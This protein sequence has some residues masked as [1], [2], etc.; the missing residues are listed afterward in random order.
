MTKALLGITLH[1]IR[2]HSIKIYEYHTMKKAIICFIL[3]W[4]PLFTADAGN[5]SSENPGIV[6]NQVRKLLGQQ[7]S[8]EEQRLFK[9]SL[10]P[11]SEQLLQSG[12]SHR[13]L[14][15]ESLR[16]IGIGE[17]FPE[18]FAT[19]IPFDQGAFRLLM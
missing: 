14:E 19:T 17:V 4:L 6:A 16:S 3:A 1:D 18:F 13:I 12:I 5:T 7:V 2:F 11:V 9:E 8:F 10:E 15:F